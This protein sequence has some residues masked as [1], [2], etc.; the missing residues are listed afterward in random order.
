[1]VTTVTTIIV[2][3]A[4]NCILDESTLDYCLLQ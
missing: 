1:M 3:A 4:P 2:A